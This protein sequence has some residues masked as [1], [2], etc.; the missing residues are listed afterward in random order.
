VAVTPGEDV[1]VI[2]PDPDPRP[3]TP[4]GVM[5]PESPAPHQPAP[6]PTPGSA[7]RVALASGLFASVVLLVFSFLEQNTAGASTFST[8]AL[9][10]LVLLALVSRRGR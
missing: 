6:T 2:G 3:M 9:V 1:L 7:R 8:L 10:L 5:T 4:V